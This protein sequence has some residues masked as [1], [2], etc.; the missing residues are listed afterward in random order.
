VRRIQQSA[1]G[2]SF[3]TRNP[4]SNAVGL[5]L[6]VAELSQL[7]DWLR[8]IGYRRIGIAGT[9]LGGYVAAL[10]AT[11]TSDVDR[12]ILDRP[13]VR[14][15][16]PLWRIAR[17][18]A[19]SALDELPSLL[20]AIYAPVSPFERSL[21]LPGE[22]VDFLLGREDRIV[23]SDAAVALAARWG[24]RVEWFEGGHVLS[25]GRRP[26]LIEMMERLPA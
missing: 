2:P 22:R 8:G 26:R 14:M 10:H 9:S 12:V 11:V 20:D 1:L 21:R 23:G 16:E 6:A 15:S 19:R 18:S 13:L 17:R 4:L 3:P 7:V 5:T 24:S 25:L